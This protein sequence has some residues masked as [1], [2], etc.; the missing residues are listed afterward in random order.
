MDSHSD[1][2]SLFLDGKIAVIRDK[3][4]LKRAM[5]APTD[6][7]LAAFSQLG[8][9]ALRFCIAG[10]YDAARMIYTPERYKN[11]NDDKQRRKISHLEPML[12]AY[13]WHKVTEGPVGPEDAVID[14]GLIADFEYPIA[15]YA[16]VHGANRSTII[17]D[18]R[19]DNPL[20]EDGV[21]NAEGGTLREYFGR[22][23]DVV[24]VVNLPLPPEF[25][26]VPT[27]DV[28]QDYTVVNNFYGSIKKDGVDQ[29]K[30]KLY[31]AALNWSLAGRD[32][33]IDNVTKESTPPPDEG[34]SMNPSY[35][36]GPPGK[37]WHPGGWVYES[38]DKK[39]ANIC[40]VFFFDCGDDDKETENEDKEPVTYL[41]VRQDVHFAC[42]PKKGKS[43]KDG[44]IYFILDDVESAEG[45]DNGEPIW[46]EMIH[47]ASLADHEDSDLKKETGEW[48]PQVMVP[49][50]ATHGDGVKPNDTGHPP[51]HQQTA[52]QPPIVITGSPRRLGF[53]PSGT[54]G[55]S[56]TL[57]HLRPPRKNKSKISIKQE[58]DLSA[59][60]GAESIVLEMHYQIITDGGSM[61]SAYTILQKT[62]DASN[63]PAVG[64]TKFTIRWSLGPIPNH[65]MVNLRMYRKAD[66]LSDDFTGNINFAET[67]WNWN[68]SV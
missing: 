22:L 62:L 21:A 63:A 36:G 26:T 59:G 20:D 11:L 3:S 24:K 17:R 15:D 4:F 58:C 45:V 39:L 57:P 41:D 54:T 31:S 2:Q 23:H 53:G 13:R 35:A 67:S 65:S 38:A 9:N 30:L 60:I 6:S 34:F 10:E 8:F 5:S 18:V 51:G 28:S 14:I 16:H 33:T 66:D 47:D 7:K 1:V 49:Y 42:A 25:K 27:P 29:T 44:R 56:W 48:R 12:F 43:H 64:G 50:V 52:S 19:N 40:S 32:L 68:N 37:L 46:G 55:L 61:S